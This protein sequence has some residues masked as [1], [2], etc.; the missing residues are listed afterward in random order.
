MKIKALA[1]YWK[2]DE[3]T[4]LFDRLIIVQLKVWS[5]GSMK[6][7]RQ[8]NRFTAHQTRWYIVVHRPQY[9]QIFMPK[10]CLLV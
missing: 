5:T 4:N 2:N 10:H 1:T 9:I 7:M 6:I 3:K 8:F